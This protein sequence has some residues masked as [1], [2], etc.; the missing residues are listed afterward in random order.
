MLGRPYG[1]RYPPGQR[2]WITA[3]IQER[4]AGVGGRGN[5]RTCAGRQP[6][7]IHAVVR[8]IF[9]PDGALA[10]VL[11]VSGH[12][13]R[14]GRPNGRPRPNE[15]LSARSLTPM[16][17]NIAVLD[18]QGTRSAPSI[19]PGRDSRAITPPRPPVKR[20]E[21]AWASTIWMCCGGLA[22]SPS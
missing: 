22:D 3:Q 17:A 5:T 13:P 2:E 20:S 14:R 16:P 8:R 11:G 19:A 1:E 4:V 12:Q 7:L 9:R 10:G 6:R 21:R 18:A 15:R